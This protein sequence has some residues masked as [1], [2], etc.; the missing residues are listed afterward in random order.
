M[1]R[2][3][4]HKELVDA[5]IDGEHA[6]RDAA[7]HAATT[8]GVQGEALNRLFETLLIAR[9]SGRI[10]AQQ[11]RNMWAEAWRSLS[12]G[13]FAQVAQDII[14]AAGDVERVLAAARTLGS[15][16]RKVEP[17]RDVDKMAREQERAN[18]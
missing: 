9:A 6:A 5:L 14:D 11:A 17:I 4:T 3:G 15:E 13:V 10:G 16:V 8:G 7:E 1:A 18:G 12:I 2:P